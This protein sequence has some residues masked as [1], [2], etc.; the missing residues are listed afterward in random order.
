MKRSTAGNRSLAAAL[1]LAASGASHGSWSVVFSE[2]FDADGLIDEELWTTPIWDP[3]C[4]PAWIPRTALRNWL[5]AYGQSELCVQDGSAILT[6]ETYNPFAQDPGDSFYGT[7]IDT[8]DRF[9]VGEGLAM[10]ARVWIDPALPRGAVMSLFGYRREGTCAG[11]YIT[12]EID[13]EIL[14][15]LY[16]DDPVSLLT[17]VYVD[18]PPGVGHPEV[19]PVTATFPGQY[20][21]IRIEW[22]PD[23]IRWRVNGE[24][25]HERMD[26]VPAGELEVRLNTW[27][28]DED[29]GLAY[30]GD[31]LPVDTPG[32]NTVY[33]YRVDYVIVERWSCEADFNDDGV[34]AT[35]DLLQ[36][37][38]TWGPCAGC[39]TDLNGDGVVST[40][41]LLA[42]LGEWGP[43][44]EP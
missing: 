33:E 17:N 1:V 27:A 32:E 18:E 31:F 29:F 11:G 22:F 3:E 41:D 26:L 10:E 16:L 6:L 42:L 2:Q 19:V 28:P 15:N 30:D 24:L 34:V 43:C 23:R 4:N 39:E 5:Q 7:E 13:L 14:S 25:V 35:S 36:L 9:E 40:A 37:L 38:G 20:N 21:V 8:L 44:L 12:N